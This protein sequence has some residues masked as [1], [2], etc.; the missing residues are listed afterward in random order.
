VSRILRLALLAPDIV[1]EI[2]AGTADQALVLERLERPPPTDWEEQR[3]PTSPVVRPVKLPIAAPIRPGSPRL[4]GMRQAAK[5]CS[6]GTRSSTRANAGGYRE[7]FGLKADY[8]MTVPKYA[9][10]RRGVALRTGLGRPKK[11][12]TRRA[13]VDCTPEGAWIEPVGNN[14]GWLVTPKRSA[15]EQARIG[16]GAPAERHR[17]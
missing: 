13:E 6:S 9:Q 3:D 11:A 10:Q 7:R 17:C 14:R 1:E 8:P 15:V 5:R 12:G 2:L 4:P 16:R